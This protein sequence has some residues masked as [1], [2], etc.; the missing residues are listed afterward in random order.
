VSDLTDQFDQLARRGTPRGGDSVLADAMR[1]AERDETALH[2]V[3]ELTDDAGDADGADGVRVMNIENGRKR[4]RRHFSSLVAAAGVA[5]TLFVCTLALTSFLGAG[6]GSDSPEGAV[7]QLADAVSREDPVAAADVLVPDEVQSLNQTVT[8]ASKRAQELALARS[9]A[10]PLSGLDLSVDNLTLSSQT[11]ADGYVKVTVSGGALT[12]RTDAQKLSPVLQKALS[13]SS[14]NTASVNL[15]ALAQGS[16]LPT[17][18][19]AIER[20]GHWYV[21]ATYTLLEYIRETNNLPA[22]EFGSG[23]RAIATLGADSPDAAVQDAMRALAADDWQSL[24]A[25]APPNELPL[26]DYRA[27]LTQ[28]GQEKGNRFTINQ[29]DTTSTVNG[30]AAKVKLTASGTTESGTWAIDGGCFKPPIDPSQGYVGP[31]A[32]RD[33]CDVPAYFFVLPFFGSQPDEAKAAT[34]KAVRVDGRWFVSPVG[35]VLD[36]LDRWV[37]QVTRRQLYSIIG[38]PQELPA[39]GELALGVTQTVGAPGDGAYAY[40]FEGK[41]GA[42]YLGASTAPP[43]YEDSFGDV[44]VY[45]PDDKVL[46]NS[47]DLIDGTG[48]ALPADGVY[49]IVVWPYGD[50]QTLTIWDEASAPETAKHPPWQGDYDGCEPIG[51]NGMVCHGSAS[52]SASGGSGETS[53][54]SGA[55]DAP[56]A[57]S[58]ATYTTAPT[59]TPT[60]RSG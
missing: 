40:S 13:R 57:T 41:R 26:Y 14:G 12:A 21:S 47:F 17:F 23:R 15:A 11:L 48:L 20:D 35:T 59:P 24:S 58:P 5:A 18:V 52:S 22:A 45:G 54:G 30:D 25:L 28:L 42:R 46:Q 53:G 51:G 32:E 10:A 37:G 8:T 6:G 9:A 7:R 3:T 31:T 29:L 49:K 4:P 50:G 27:A 34:I 19:I 2:G 56:S 60:I 36:L 39:D 43:G 55:V 1:A 16:N 44:R 33:W 38:A